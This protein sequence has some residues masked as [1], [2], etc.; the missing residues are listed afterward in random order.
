LGVGTEALAAKAIG[1]R[2]D[3]PVI[4]IGPGP[5]FPGTGAQG[6]AVEG[7]PAV[8]TLEQALQQIACPTTRLAGMPT[9]FLQLLLHR[10]EHR[11]FDDGG[12]RD[13]NPVWGRHIIVRR[14]PPWLQRSAPLRPQFGA[15]RPLPGLPEGRTA[16]IRRIFQYRPDH[17]PFPHE[18]ACARPLAR[19]HEPATDVADGQSLTADPLEDL[20][21]HAGLIRDEVIACVAPTGML[22]DVAVAI[23]GATEHIDRPH[24]GRVEFAPSVAFDN[25]G[26]FILGHHPLHLEQ[27]IIFRATP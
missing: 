24:P 21:N 8:L 14:G 17:T 4:G 27:Q 22:A 23:G 18:A 26:P 13:V 15:Q 7:I 11:G 20:V 19:L 6:F 9:V 16:H 2:A 1:I 25:L 12:H 5:T 3:T 10:G